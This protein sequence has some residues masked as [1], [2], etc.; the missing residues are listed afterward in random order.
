MALLS[1]ELPYLFKML[2]DNP[3]SG[4]LQIKLHVWEYSIVCLSIVEYNSIYIQRWAIITHNV[5]SS[6][7]K[8]LLKY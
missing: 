2:G 5:I 7:I 8:I 6:R 1:A 3:I 4:H